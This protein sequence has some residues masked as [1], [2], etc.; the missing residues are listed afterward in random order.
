MMKSALLCA[1]AVGIGLSQAHADG[2]SA[3]TL[4]TY[5]E[6]SAGGRGTADDFLGGPAA[7]L[8]GLSAATLRGESFLGMAA[9]AG[10]LAVLP[11]RQG[12][13]GAGLLHSVGFFPAANAAQD[14]A[15]L[16]AT[17]AAPGAQAGGQPWLLAAGLGLIALVVRRRIAVRE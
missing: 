4:I 9:S 10:E 1:A 14:V 3:A 16:A 17:P 15:R 7:A 12:L 2:Y 13:G 5:L 6:R 11:R 8:H